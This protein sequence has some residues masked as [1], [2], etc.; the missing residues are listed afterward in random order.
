MPSS[1]TEP[2]TTLTGRLREIGPGIIISGAIVGSGELIVTTKLGA[3]TGLA[4]LWLILFSCIIKV[5]LQI[6]LGRYVVS[7]GHTVLEAFDRVPGP[8]LPIGSGRLNW[9]NALWLVMAICAALQIGGILL[10]LALVFEIPA[11]GLGGLPGAAWALAFAL[12]TVAL[13]ASGRYGLIERTT[14][15]LVGMFT[16]VTIVAAVVVQG[17]DAAVTGE[18]I[19]R[20]LTPSIPPDG[21]VTAFAVLGITGVGANELIFYPYWCLEKGYA[22]HV[23][24]DDGSSA[25][26]ERAR[27]WVWVMQLDAWI[28]CAIYTIGTVAFYLLGA[29]VLHQR[30]LQ[31]DDEALH[32]SLSQI[33][34]AGLGDGVGTWVYAAGAVA[35][36]FS[37]FFV[38]AASTSRI[39]TDAVHVFGIRQLDAAARKRLIQ[40]LGVALPLFA[41][42][43]AVTVEK[44]VALVLIGAV[45]QAAMLPFLALATCLLRYRW[46]RSDLA[47]RSIIDPFLWLAVLSTGGICVYQ[48]LAAFDVL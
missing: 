9:M 45:A 27:G 23:G 8:A 41:W 10:S 47:P 42:A 20:G 1:P 29:A 13:L 48:M 37:T 38:W 14:A 31:V 25:W 33:Y 30:G 19:A 18:Q 46:T 4:L 34:T 16:L 21:I 39:V 24:P 7:S 44:P 3:E 36:L 2:P 6:E 12:I 26:L 5:F 15:L 28:A 35:V 22:R 17:T 40:V 43:V 11:V 32:A